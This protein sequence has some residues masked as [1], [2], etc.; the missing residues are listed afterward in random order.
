MT[1]CQDVSECCIV[2]YSRILTGMIWKYME[3][4]L[5]DF[6]GS[7]CPYVTTSPRL[8]RWHRW[9][10]W[11][12]TATSWE[13]CWHPFPG[14]TASHPNGAL[15]PSSF[16]MG[17][18][19]LYGALDDEPSRWFDMI[20][21]WDVSCLISWVNQYP[22]R[23]S[24]QDIYVPLSFVEMVLN[25]NAE[26]EQSFSFLCAATNFV[27]VKCQR[28]A[29]AASSK[30][31]W[32]SSPMYVTNRR[33]VRQVRTVRQATDGFGLSAWALWCL[34]SGRSAVLSAT[35]NLMNF[36]VLD[37]FQLLVFQ[38]FA[39]TLQTAAMLCG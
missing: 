15:C 24:I 29:F 31:P 17:A 37:S 28:V 2:T 33:T 38:V 1:L 6:G 11:H 35:W 14:P 7:W 18:R 22:W 13:T 12:P 39:E 8:N 20:R 26:Q 30:I 34:N 21:W 25:S 10:W 4:C 23:G 19:Y 27:K 36:L 9:H 3:L 16:L 32:D 5:L